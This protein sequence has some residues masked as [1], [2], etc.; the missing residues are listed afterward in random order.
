MPAR[1]PAGP[2]AP[3]S[4]PKKR[5]VGGWIPPTDV[6]EIKVT[7]RETLPPVWRRILVQGNLTLGHLHRVL[8]IAMG[9]QECHMHMFRVRKKSYG[10]QAYEMDDGEGVSNGDHH[11]ITVAQAFKTGK[12][13]VVYEYDFGD[14]WE[15]DLKVVKVHPPEAAPGFGPECVAGERAC[16]PEDVGGTFGYEEFLEAMAD[17]KHPRHEELS[18]WVSEMVDGPFDPDKFDMAAVNKD[19][20]RLR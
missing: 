20:K 10:D 7:L 9:W 17:P 5:E 8:Q 1:R 15:H 6:Y 11:D 18:E 13:R 4:A 3:R 12:G 19:L 2:P 16:P 14:S